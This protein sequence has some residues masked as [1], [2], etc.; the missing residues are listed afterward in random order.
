MVKGRFEER[1]ETEA[2]A[3]RS[4]QLFNL[5]KRFGFFKEDTR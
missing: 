1:M 4:V 2:S 3:C 5:D